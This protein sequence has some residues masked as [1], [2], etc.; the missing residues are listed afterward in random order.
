M[1]TILVTGTLA[2]ALFISPSRAQVGINADNSAPDPSAMLDVK[3]QDKGFLPP[4]ITTSQRNS[5]PTPATG[6]MI[7][8]T[9]CNDLQYYNGAAWVPVGNSGML[10]TPGS[11]SGNATPCINE[12]GVAYS[13]A[14]VSGSTAYHWIVP[15]GAVITGGQGTTTVTVSFG[16]SSGAVCVS[17]VNDCYRSALSCLTV[18]LQN[19]LPVSVIIVPSANPVCAGSTV[20]FTATPVNGGPYPAYQW[21]VNGSNLPGATNATCNIA[22]S[23]NDVITCVMTSNVP[24]VTGNPA[25]SNPVAMTVTPLLPVSVTIT[26]SANPACPS[27]QVTFL[28]TPVN[29]GSN[30]TYTWYKNGA[31]TGGNSPGYT[32]TPAN[33]DV[34]YCRLSSNAPCVSGNPASSNSITMTIVPYLTV[35]VSITAS[36]NPSCNYQPVTYTATPVNGGTSPSF[37]W[38]VNGS[39]IPGAIN[40]TYTFVPFHNDNIVCILTSSYTCPLGNP[41]TSN[42]ITMAV[43]SHV[44]AIHVAGPWSPYTT[45][46]NYPITSN[47]PGENT[48]C[49][50]TRNLGASQQPA[51]VWEILQASAGWYWQ[52]NRTQGYSWNGSNRTPNTTWITFISENSNWLPAN[53]PCTHNLGS[54][55]RIPTYSE[56]YNVDNAGGWTDWWGP[57]NSPLKLHAA[58]FINYMSGTVLGWGSFGSFWSSTQYDMSNGNSL[59]IDSN[60]SMMSYGAKAEGCSLRCIK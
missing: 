9:D 54:P 37:Q 13:V 29:G 55:W 11:I 44:T 30:P 21:Q 19:L 1:K 36:A 34:I 39:V 43:Q 45:T 25:T 47:L 14:P 48:K 52:F 20:T 28:A 51:V 57:W 8:N 17:A 4:R 22:P 3:A 16:T 23:N 35:S 56:W 24:C 15:Q 7:Y 6:L 18:T 12:A 50:I 40:S 41:A 42:T 59:Y 38:K 60:N 27:T 10:P 2:I 26:A 46:I 5:I 49:W 32:Y 31:V 33:N 58:G 53:D